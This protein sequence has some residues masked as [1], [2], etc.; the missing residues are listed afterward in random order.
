MDTKRRIKRTFLISGA[1]LILLGASVYRSLPVNPPT[2]AAHVQAANLELPP[3]VDAMLHRSCGNCH[4]N[5]TRW[6]WYTHLRPVAALMERDVNRARRAMNLSEWSIQNGHS[7][8]SAIGTLAAS[9]AEMQAGRM[10]LPQYRMLHPESVLTR[11]D[12]SSF[13]E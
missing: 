1:T 12:V 13:C 9:C 6:P 7:D 3:P 11:K 5:Q 8:S 10:P 2:H 4:G